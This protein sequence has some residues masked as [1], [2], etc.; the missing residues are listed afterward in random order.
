[1]LKNLI[2]LCFAVLLF[3]ACSD[4]DPMVDLCADIECGANG[5]CTTGTCDC[6]EGYYGDS[7]E[8][9]IVDLF[10]GTWNGVDCEGDD[11]TII[12][13]AGPTPTDLIILNTGLEITAEIESQSKFIMPSQMITEPFFGITF[14]VDGDGTL[15]ADGT[16]S[17]SAN[18]ASPLG[19]GS[20]TAIM[21]KQ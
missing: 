1:M 7:C 4:D 10:I 3:T 6:D 14:T 16:L 18:V 9:A 15:L 2:Y 5:T 13:S 19:G 21:T 11:Y 20:C 17:F 8:N 12:I